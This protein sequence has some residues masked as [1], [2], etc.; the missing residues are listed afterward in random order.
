MSFLDKKLSAR[1]KSHFVV[2]L[3]V[4]LLSISALI[5]PIGKAYSNDSR[6][7]PAP[8]P[9]PKP[10]FSSYKSVTIGMDVA[11][12]RKALGDAADKSDAQ[13]FYIISEN[14]T[15]QVFYDDEKK[16]VAISIDYSA[17]FKDP[18]TAMKV[19]G[20]DVKPGPEGRI[21]KLIRYPKAGIWVSFSRTAGDK[22]LTSVT[23]KRIDVN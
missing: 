10:I 7:I 15:L 6:L 20:E 2:S 8:T 3:V 16:V 9:E 1:G 19:L 11:D 21:Y 23:I 22:P 12:A 5:G 18:P 14:E 13:D 4:G 17:E